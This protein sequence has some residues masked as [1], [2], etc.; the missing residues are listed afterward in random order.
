MLQRQRTV[1]LP[2]R[3]HINPATVT[4][5]MTFSLHIDT[6]IHTKTVCRMMQRW[7]DKC[8]CLCADIP[9]LPSISSMNG[10]DEEEPGGPFTVHWLNNKEL[11]LTLSME[12]FQQQL[13][14]RRAERT[15][16]AITVLFA[17]WFVSGP[18]TV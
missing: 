5:G 6:R 13:E 2:Q 16:R 17:Q 9:L 11:H 1:P 8:E 12:V 3:R 10:S 14:Q 4:H 7:S 18:V 15:H